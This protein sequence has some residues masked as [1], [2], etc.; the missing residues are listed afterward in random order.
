M[1]WAQTFLIWCLLIAVLV[2]ARQIKDAQSCTVQSFSI[3]TLDFRN[4]TVQ[5]VLN[6]L[7]GKRP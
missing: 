5:D 2:A 3:V 7:S 1:S 6:L 4:V